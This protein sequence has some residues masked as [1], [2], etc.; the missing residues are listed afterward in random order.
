VST[1]L[2]VAADLNYARPLAV[3]L[4]S[5]DEQLSAGD[6]LEVLVVGTG[7][8]ASMR[9]RIASD[10][11]QLE[12]RF[13]DLDAQ[14]RFGHLPNVGHLSRSA[15]SRLAIPELLPGDVERFV[16]IDV[17]VVVRRDLRELAT[18][19]LEGMLLAAVPDV[20]APCLGAP[21]GLPTWRTLALDPREPYMNTGVM[22]ADVG[23]WRDAGLVAS[24]AAYL[25]RHADT[26]RWADQDGFNA[27]AHGRWKRLDLTWNAQG[28]LHLPGMWTDVFFDTAEADEARRAPGIIH[29]SNT[30][31][32]NDT[33]RASTPWAEHWFDV[34]SRTDFPD[35][36]RHAGFGRRAAGEARRRVR[37]S[38]AAL[39]QP[40]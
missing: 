9:R 36:R 7:L 18:V 2:A 15:Y 12:L 3:T 10:L 33:A 20:G 38:I 8:D 31:P 32:W 29:Y 14:R 23:A 19:D 6:R 27:C 34:A 28:A 22:V 37:A 11:T 26:L 1:T 17:D 35:D 16:Y 4:R 24:I 13:V 30:K 40:T 21:E 5:V 25:A 39:A